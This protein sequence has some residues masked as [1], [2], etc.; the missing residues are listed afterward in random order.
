MTCG[1]S[2]IKY[3]VSD[4]ADVDSDNYCLWKSCNG[5]FCTGALHVRSFSNQSTKICLFL[6][7]WCGVISQATDKKG[8]VFVGHF[9]KLLCC[10]EKLASQISSFSNVFL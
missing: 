9:K 4:S 5:I 6:V 7:G 10:F 1:T 8:G 2:S 3:K